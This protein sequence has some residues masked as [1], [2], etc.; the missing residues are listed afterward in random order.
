MQVREATCPS[1]FVSFRVPNKILARVHDPEI[2]PRLP[3]AEFRADGQRHRLVSDGHPTTQL[4][5]LAHVP[6]INVSLICCSLTFT[7]TMRSRMKAFAVY[8]NFL[9]VHPSH[10]SIIVFLP[11]VGRA[12]NRLRFRVSRLLGGRY[13]PETRRQ[14]GCVTLASPLGCHWP[15]FEPEADAV[16]WFQTETEHRTPVCC[17]WCQLKM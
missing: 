10:D 9:C 5:F 17:P 7:G 8:L 14:S 2:T 12:C 3:A 15:I 4:P 1:P 16:A 11:A 13:A 6:A